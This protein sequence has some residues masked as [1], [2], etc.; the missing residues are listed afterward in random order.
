MPE[1]RAVYEV[2][3]NRGMPVPVMEVSYEGAQ[4]YGPLGLNRHN[5]HEMDYVGEGD[6]VCVR[7]RHDYLGEDTRHRFGLLQVVQRARGPR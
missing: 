6:I 2:L 1:C 4:R 5:V 3:R 7:D